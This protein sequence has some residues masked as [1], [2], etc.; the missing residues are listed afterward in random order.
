MS[1]RFPDVTWWC[2]ACGANL[3]CQEGFDDHKYTWKCTECGYKNSISRDNIFVEQEDYPN[4]LGESDDSSEE[5]DGG[6]ISGIFR[7][8]F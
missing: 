2:D 4:I 8:F 7:R 3:N 5:S 1:K 6:F